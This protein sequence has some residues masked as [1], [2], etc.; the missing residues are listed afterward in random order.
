MKTYIVTE[1][2]SDVR[3]LKSVLHSQGVLNV[4]YIAA[5]GKSSVISMAQ[6]LLVKRHQPVVVVMDADIVEK[7]RADEQSKIYFDLLRNFASG[8]AFRVMLLVPELEA[9]FFEDPDILRN[10]LNLEMSLISPFEAEDRPK[11]TLQRI[12][13]QHG[14]HSREDFINKLASDSLHKLSRTPFFIELASFLSSP[15]DSGTWTSNP[16][17][18]TQPST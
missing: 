3:L 17:H 9:V 15:E 10:E 16:R 8:T 18:L 7:R 1:G 12:L 14:F 11:E 6:S 13:R 2:K 5:G 4:E